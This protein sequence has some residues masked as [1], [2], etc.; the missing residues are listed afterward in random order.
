LNS[1][2]CFQ[3]LVNHKRAS[4]RSGLALGHAAMLR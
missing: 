3:P 4:A 2:A 1:A